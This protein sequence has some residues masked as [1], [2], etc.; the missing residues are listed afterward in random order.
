VS[1]DTC[2]VL[3]TAAVYFEEGLQDTPVYTLELLTPGT[4]IA[5]PAVIIDRNSTM[6]VEPQCVATMTERGDI[7]IKVSCHTDACARRVSVRLKRSL[8]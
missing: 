7:V 4:E 5:G 3:Q 2:F 8:C 1:F 6:V